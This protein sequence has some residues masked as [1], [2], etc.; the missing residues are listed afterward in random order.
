MNRKRKASVTGSCDVD[1]L[2]QG[3]VLYHRF[4]LDSRGYPVK[5]TIT[6][7][8]RWKRDPA[9]FRL[10]VK[11]GRYTYFAIETE[12]ALSAWGLSTIRKDED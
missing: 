6:S 10:G 12:S 7:I 5:A 1:K 11:H 3:Q 4:E 9:R 2:R 8:K